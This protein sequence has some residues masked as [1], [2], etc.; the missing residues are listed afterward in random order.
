MQSVATVLEKK[1][2][3]HLIGVTIPIVEA[4]K[5]SPTY[6]GS[7][8]APVWTTQKSPLCVAC[9]DWIFFFNADTVLTVPNL[10]KQSGSN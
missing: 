2:P 6:S 4:T 1:N 9:K 8:T 7:S 3:R 10:T 5:V